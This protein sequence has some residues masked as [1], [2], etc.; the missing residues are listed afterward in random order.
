MSKKITLVVGRS[1]Q[2]C[3]SVC[4]HPPSSSPHP[5]PT[6]IILFPF[7]TSSTIPLQLHSTPRPRPLSSS[8]SFLIRR[9]CRCSSS[10]SSIIPSSSSSRRRSKTSRLDFCAI[11]S[12]SG[13][14]IL[15]GGVVSSLLLRRDLLLL[16]FAGV[17]DVEDVETGLG[18]GL[19]LGIWDGRRGWGAYA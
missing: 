19:D 5:P 13:V 15:L 4:V 17:E 2:V 8:R 1:S 16:F 9:M 18:G 11:N 7:I 12:W 6:P 14:E 10:N 3:R